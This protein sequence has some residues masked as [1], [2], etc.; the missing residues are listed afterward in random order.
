MILSYLII[1]NTIATQTK[2]D[3]QTYDG[4]KLDPKRLFQT[5]DVIG[6]GHDFILCFNF[7]H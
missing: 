2:F 4:L 5:S 1:Y 3:I 7:L 6:Q